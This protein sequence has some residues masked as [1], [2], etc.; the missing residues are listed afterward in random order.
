MSGTR[1]GSLVM[2]QRKEKGKGIKV[3]SGYM[4]I[5]YL[6]MYIAKGFLLSKD[7]FICNSKV[8][9]NSLLSDYATFISD[10]RI[11]ISSKYFEMCV[12]I[13]LMVHL[14]FVLL[15]HYSN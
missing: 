12:I 10:N 9:Q 11:F 4:Y 7:P 2:M 8:L 3:G 1:V 13:A 15:N 6:Y 5:C 14:Y